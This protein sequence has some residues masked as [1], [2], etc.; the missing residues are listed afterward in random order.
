ME[1]SHWQNNLTFATFGRNFIAQHFI[2]EATSL[3][4]TSFFKQKT[5]WG[6]FIVPHTACHF[7]LNGGTFLG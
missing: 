1:I 7:L 2:G 4:S 6:T 3:R 5:V